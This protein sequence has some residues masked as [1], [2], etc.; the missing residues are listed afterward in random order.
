MKKAFR[1]RNAVFDSGFGA[2]RK[3]I[4]YRKNLYNN[5]RNGCK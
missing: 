1:M 2:S 5:E 4:G 3:K